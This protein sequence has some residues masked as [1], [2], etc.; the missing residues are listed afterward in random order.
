MKWR[1][2]SEEEVKAV[3]TSPDNLQEAIKG[4]RNAVKT[5]GERLLKVAYKLEHD[6][7]VVVT[8]IDK[9]Q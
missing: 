2:I 6:R 3:V 7:I 9:K 1:R 8:V 4:R 5:I